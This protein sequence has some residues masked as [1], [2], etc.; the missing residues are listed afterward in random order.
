MSFWGLGLSMP[1]S[2]ITSG[3]AIMLWQALDESS[4]AM[5]LVLPG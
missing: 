5:S 3:S 4:Y 1:I 2:E